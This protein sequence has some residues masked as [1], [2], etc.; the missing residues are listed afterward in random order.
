ACAGIPVSAVWF[1][2]GRNLLYF[3]VKLFVFR[4]I[5]RGALR[6]AIGI[7][8]HSVDGAIHANAAG[9]FA[10]SFDRIGGTEIDDFRALILSHFQA[11]GD[12]VN[13]DD[14]SGT[15]KFG[16]GDDEL[17]DGTTT[18]NRDRGAGVNVGYFRAEI[19]S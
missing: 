13:G 17:A 7:D 3:A 4:A 12:S 9:Q 10:D 8:A 2:L 1:S 11:R 19:A 5:V 6:R 14:A 18:E 16:A 15:E